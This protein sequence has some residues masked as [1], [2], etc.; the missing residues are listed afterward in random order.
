MLHPTDVHRSGLLRLVLGAVDVGPRRG[1]QDEVGC[2]PGG[3][4]CVTSQS[5]R[6]RPRA[7]GKGLEQRVP[8]LPAAP[9]YEHAAASRGERIGVCVLHRCLTRGSSQ[10]SPCSSGSA[11]S[12]SRVTW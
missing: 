12:Y 2:E 6:V 3:A 10:Q 9:G 1:V 7:V 4:G 5:V 11:G 8:E